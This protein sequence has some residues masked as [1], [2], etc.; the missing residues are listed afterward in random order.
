MPSPPRACPSSR[1]RP[2]SLRRRSPARRQRGGL[3][4]DP[5]RP[6]VRYPGA[7]PERGG[8]RSRPGR[9]R[10]RDRGL[11]GG[12]G[13]VQP[14]EHQ[15]RRS[16]SRSCAFSG[17]PARAGV[18]DP[19]ARLRSTVSA[20]RTRARPPSRAARVAQRLLD[21][22]LRRAL[23][24]RH[25]RRR[26]FPRR[27]PRSSDAAW[28]Q[29][30]PSASRAPFPRYARNGARQRRRRAEAGVTIFDSSAGGLG[31]CPYAPGAAGNSRPRTS[32]IS[33]TAWV[34]RRVWIFLW[35]QGPRGPCRARSR[36]D[37]RRV[38]IRL[39]SRPAGRGPW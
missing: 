39:S 33:C 32:C 18:Q 12:V 10:P 36:A 29:A 4:A 35:S 38:S 26:T 17:G 31:G 34:T 14:E 19:R 37:R 25:D 30:C 28:T 24:R 16:T 11:H 15:R 8:A 22:G 3:P 13:H 27:C 20:A 7:R 1:R 9:G 23:A 2:S 21:R 6:G 5:K